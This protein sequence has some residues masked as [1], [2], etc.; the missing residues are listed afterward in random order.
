MLLCCVTVPT[1]EFDYFY[2]YYLN[3]SFL[4]YHRPIL[5]YLRQ[6]YVLSAVV[7]INEYEYYYYDA[8]HTKL[9]LQRQ[10]TL[11]PLFFVIIIINI[12][13]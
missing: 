1:L 7:L 5:F 3:L 13:I 11:L 2:M 4:P 6:S 8:R 9:W 10:F 12:I